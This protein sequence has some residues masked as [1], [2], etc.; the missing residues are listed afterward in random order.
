L[1]NWIH[2]NRRKMPQRRT[3]LDIANQNLLSPSPSTFLIILIFR[4]NWKLF[5]LN[6]LGSDFDYSEGLGSSTNITMSL[7]VRNQSIKLLIDTYLLILL[8]L[9]PP[10]L[11]SSLSFAHQFHS[12]LLFIN[13][14]RSAAVNKSQGQSLKHVGVY[15]PYQHLYF[16][17]TIVCCC[18]KSYIQRRTKDIDTNVTSNV[19]YERVFC[20]VWWNYMT[21]Y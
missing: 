7:D 21:M 5:K 1:E 17:C 13:F 16:S 11:I 19:V 10:N 18:F 9:H 20:N 15:L 4:S 8:S 6:N 12:Y 3:V 2:P 14:V